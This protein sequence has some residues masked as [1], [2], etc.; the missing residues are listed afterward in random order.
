MHTTY[1]HPVVPLPFLPKELSNLTQIVSTA[2]ATSTTVFPH[3]L[4]DQ[5][6]GRPE[7]PVT[8]VA[9]AAASSGFHESL[10]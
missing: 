8:G 7:S 1:K 9:A 10:M 2:I 5:L 4:F 6:I 3:P